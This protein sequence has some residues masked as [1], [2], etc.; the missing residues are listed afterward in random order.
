MK[1][2]F[3]YLEILIAVSLAAIFFLLLVAWYGSF[4]RKMARTESYYTERNYLINKAEEALSFSSVTSGNLI[5]GEV[6]TNN[7]VIEYLGY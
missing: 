4:S 7:L 3:S 2:A 5:A 1:K 6:S